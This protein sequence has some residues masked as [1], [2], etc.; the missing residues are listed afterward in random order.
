MTEKIKL[1]ENSVFKY[2][3]KT[4]SVNEVKFI[5][6]KAVIITNVKT[7]VKY[8]NEL[9]E[10]LKVI[11]FVLPEMIT[12]SEQNKVEIMKPS[13]EKSIEIYMPKTS[14]EVEEVN[15]LS[16]RVS[17][18]LEEIF[19]ELATSTYDENLAKKADAMV[20]ASNAIVVNEM[21]RFKY[22]TLI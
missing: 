2:E 16:K 13:I 3:N 11:E 22:L 15:A 18:K 9:D 12:K 21:M 17:A 4:H 1:F 14:K 5:Q 10:F 20:R 7:F 6:N 8:E 19:N